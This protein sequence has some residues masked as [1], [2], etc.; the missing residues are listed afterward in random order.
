MSEK[1]IAEQIA[2]LR[3]MRVPDLMVRYE[4]VHGKPPRVKHREW[5]WRRIA[6]KIQEQKYGGLSIAARRRLD[7]LI[8]ELD[9]PFRTAARTTTARLSTKQPVLGTMLCRTWRDREVRATAVEGGWEHDGVVYKTLSAVANAITGTHTSGPRF[10][11]VGGKG[12]R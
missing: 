7:E 9:L 3:E 2:E 6:W 8:A 12:L 4:E 5:L 11:G 1:S 10:F